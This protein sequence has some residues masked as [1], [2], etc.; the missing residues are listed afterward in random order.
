MGSFWSVFSWALEVTKRP[1][2]A[3]DRNC[4]LSTKAIPREHSGQLFSPGTMATDQ[5]WTSQ[6]TTLSW[7]HRG[8]KKKKKKTGWENFLTRKSL[9]DNQFHSEYSVL[10]H[11]KNTQFCLTALVYKRLWEM[12]MNLR[13]CPPESRGTRQR[14]VE[15][16]LL[17]KREGNSF[18]SNCL[19]NEMHFLGCFIH[20]SQCVG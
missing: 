16:G 17:L 5:S 1:K 7:F 13:T 19:L 11:S 20:K 10:S 8:G 15:R 14:K 18:N 12:D 6:I 3:E 9:R 2:D 4:F